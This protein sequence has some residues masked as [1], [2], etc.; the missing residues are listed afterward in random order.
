LRTVISSPEVHYDR[1]GKPASF[2]GLQGS[3]SRRGK[4]LVLS[5]VNPHVSEP[6]E[7]FI[8]PRGGSFVSASA[9]TL[10]SADIHAR[11][12][13]DEPDALEP[14]TRQVQV[15]KQGLTVVFPPASVTTLS[16]A[17]S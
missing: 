11:N 8:S 12:T 2:P 3:A 15:D 13:F 10:A 7:T 9:S 6:R 16:L 14:H 5:V 4:E 17:L 1:D